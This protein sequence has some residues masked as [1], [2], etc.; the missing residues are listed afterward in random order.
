MRVERQK[1]CQPRYDARHVPHVALQ[2]VA[3]FGRLQHFFRH[4]G[5]GHF[6]IVGIMVEGIE[7]FDIAVGRDGQNHRHF[8]SVERMGKG[9]RTA[10]QEDGGKDESFH[11]GVGLMRISNY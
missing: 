1:T 2:H 11:G 3:V 4:V 10:E 5:A 9:E 6:A 8:F 7:N